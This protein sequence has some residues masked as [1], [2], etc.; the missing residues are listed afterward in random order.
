M[1][2]RAH[3]PASRFPVG[4]VV[5]SADGRL[6]GGANVES[7]DWTRGLCAERVALA[8]MLS[9]GARSATR[10]WLACPRAP[11]CTPCGACRQVL[12]ELAPAADVVMAR[13]DGHEIAT[14]ATLLPGAFDAGSL[15]G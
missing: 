1:A 5:L 4:C 3:I 9:S 13:E 10:I 2:E 7:S 14:V 11:D 12:F 6:F 15:Q 8:T